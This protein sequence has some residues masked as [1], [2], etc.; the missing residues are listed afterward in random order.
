M[1]ALVRLLQL[2]PVV[3]LLDEPTASLDPEATRRATDLIT[4]WA[5]SG[6]SERATVWV[7]HDEQLTRKISSRRLRLE[8]GILLAEG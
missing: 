2:D 8:R 4:S 3:L 1:V 7:S 6:A 5:E